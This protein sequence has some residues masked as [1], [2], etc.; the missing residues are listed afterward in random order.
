MLLEVFLTLS[1]RHCNYATDSTMKKP[2]TINL[3]KPFLLILAIC[4]L[5]IH[6]HARV[7]K[8]LAIGNSFS[9]D[10]VEQNLY[11]LAL[12]QG[13]TLIIGN[14][15]IPGCTIDRHWSNAQTGKAEYSYR[16]VTD[17]VFTKTDKVSLKDIILDENWEVISLQQ[18]SGNSGLPE[19]YGNLG[20]LKKY[21]AETATNKDAEII[22]HATWAYAN[23]YK[24]A[25]FK[26]YNS[27]Q[28]QMFDAICNTVAQ[29]LP[30]VGI[31]KYI[32]NNLTIQNAREVLGDILNRDGFHLSYTIGRYA[33][34]CTWCEFLTGKNIIGNT[35]HP[36]TISD[37]EALI[38]Q[39][40]AHKAIVESGM[41]YQTVGGFFTTNGIELIDA[42]GAPFLIA[43][44][45]N[46][47]A[48]FKEKAFNALFYIAETGANT[49]RVVWTDKGDAGELEK[50]IKRCIELKMI[51]MVE[52]HSA[53]G[54]H[55]TEP[56]LNMAKYYAR[57]D[58]ANMLKRY[59]RYLLINIANEW[60]DH[61]VKSAHWLESYTQAIAI[62]RQ[63]GFKTTLVVDAP[64][65][66]QNI[67]PILECG[68]QLIEND[69]EHNILF[70][71]HMYGSWNKEK[72]IID[73]LA[74][75]NDLNLP[76]IVGE[77]G[78]NCNNGKNNLHCKANHKTILQA[79]R[80][81]G[82]GFMPWSWTGNNEENAWLDLVE[83]S[84]WKTP[85][86]WGNEVI[87]GPSG[88]REIAKTAKVYE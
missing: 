35:Y 3:I 12:A 70:S 58:V 18:Q 25:N 31:S 57:E 55:D 73:R 27:D 33:A 19:S 61:F 53:T 14:A 69:P 79:C 34:A 16:K 72:N 2:L 64:G 26:P 82:Y 22:W 62:M 88:V 13:D 54:K 9:E 63:A 32:P 87:N 15:Y 5:P 28:K 84:D 86:W 77:F 75:A 10:A 41:V 56:L 78:Y 76:L 30:K 66:G 43:G 4:L 36:E 60:G 45:N 59:E 80:D 11:E 52:L 68:Q 81:N 23:S 24:S 42:T 7:L 46:P 51:P 71:V 20:L 29:E 83:S 21:V 8:V 40:A 6:T 74:E 1:S 65:W 85:T 38:L 47:H 50:I 39:E 44:I 67:K 49:V 17:G 37:S 48:W